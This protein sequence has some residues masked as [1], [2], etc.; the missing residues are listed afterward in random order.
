MS[1]VVADLLSISFTVVLILLSSTFSIALI[2]EKR[3]N[4][5]SI[6]TGIFTVVAV[7]FMVL[8]IV[9]F[10]FYPEPIV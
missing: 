6:L 2:D 4:Y 10:I 1:N 5:F 7:G 8:F 3:R 9:G